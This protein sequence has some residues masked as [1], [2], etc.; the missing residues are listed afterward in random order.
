MSKIKINATA[1]V[2]FRKDSARALYYERLKKFNGKTLES[3][4]KDVEKSPPSTPKKGKLAGKPEPVAGWIKW[5][6]R[7]GYA[8]VE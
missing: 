7:N 2:N 5:F 1:K 6:V 3:F 4:V 8:T